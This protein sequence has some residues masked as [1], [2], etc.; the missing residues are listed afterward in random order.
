MIRAILG[1]P[2]K[3]KPKFEAQVESLDEL[4]RAIQDI[5]AGITETKKEL[6]AQANG[7]YVKLGGTKHAGHK[8]TKL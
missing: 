8:E 5:S 7:A 2:E 3:P 1:L 6:I 4:Q